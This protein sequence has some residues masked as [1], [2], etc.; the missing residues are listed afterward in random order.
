MALQALLLTRDPDVQKTI[1]R[2]LDSASIDVDFSNNVEQ[3][4]LALTRR[5]YD[6]FLVDCD[7]MPDGPAVLRELRQGKS[8]RS[9]IA[10]ALVSGRTTVQQAFEMGAN[11]VLDKPISQE[12][13]SRSVRAAQGLIMRERRRYHRHLLKASGAIMV[14][15]GAELPV[16]ITNISAGG[17][18]IECSRQLDE[19]GAAKVRFQLPGTRRSLE[20]KGE[21]IWTTTEGR[22]GIRFQVLAVDVKKELDSW[23]DKRTLPLGNGAMF[24]NATL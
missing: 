10:F 4:R 2:V 6:A 14:D 20:I 23:L 15:S 12:R 5:K 18:S 16:S 8:N 1:K 22:A 13:A 3:A 24:I 17:I 11:F 19:G 7:D 21:V 9:C